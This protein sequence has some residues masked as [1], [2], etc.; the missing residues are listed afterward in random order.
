MS[1]FTD[2][3]FKPMVTKYDVCPWLFFRNASPDER[4]EQQ[5][6]Q[7]DLKER[8]TVEL[9]NDCFISPYA[10]IFTDSLSLGERSYIAAHAYLTDS[11]SIGSNSTVNPYTTVRGN[12][13]IGD[14]VRI[15]AHSLILAFDHIHADTTK[16]IYQQGVHSKG[17]KI[18]DDVY[19]GSNV[20]ILDGVNIASH[21]IVAAGAVVTKDVPEYAVVA[22]NPARIIKDRR[23]GKKMPATLESDLSQ[24]GEAVQEQLQNLLAS[25][26]GE[27]EGEAAY[28]QQ[29]NHEPTVRAWADAIEIA[30]MFNELPALL[31][32]E[33]YINKLQALQ[34]PETGIIPD[35]YP[36]PET[37]M[38]ALGDRN[39]D[40][41]ILSVGY[42]LECLGAHFLHPV[43]TIQSLTAEALYA[44]LE[45]LPWQT[46]AWSSGSWVDA[47]G[48]A[49]HLN[50]K[51]FGDDAT[52]LAPV[53]G[54]LN[55]KISKQFGVWGTPTPQGDWLQP[56]NGFYRLTR[57]TYAQFGLPL[58]FPEVS[59]DTILRHSRN[60]SYF[61]EDRGNACNVL[62]IVH[63]LW[64]CALQTDYRQEEIQSWATSQLKRAISKWV[65]NKGFS[66]D[67]EQAE[68][69]N[70]QCSLQGTEMWLSIIYLLAEV[71]GK[72][73]AVAYKPKGVHRIEPYPLLS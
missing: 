35:P 73:D 29:A 27:V 14:G 40:Y 7:E 55:T 53:M 8:L 41:L 43:K 21:S 28:L 15:G 39:A 66:F 18:N 64:L 5:K 57:G 69:P 23:G 42:A 20:S 61:R 54:W 59:I 2:T 13:T 58:P 11:I 71:I 30:A 1:G 19:I 37:P 68:T 10:A 60:R 50:I 72:A 4:R 70:S 51:H 17:I 49:Q 9:A 16:P 52:A 12:V 62:D 24:F 67:L 48:T 3:Q 47:Y 36:H 33:G 44:Q 32:R 56:V 34:D 38:T 22:G 46:R 63:P 26:V 65:A 25:Y 45:Q 31:N 6:V